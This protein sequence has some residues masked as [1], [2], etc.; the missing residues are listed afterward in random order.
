MRIY[1]SPSDQ[2]SNITASGHSEADH[3]LS[4]AKAAEKYLKLNGYEAKIG[5]NTTEKSYT[6]RVAES[7]NWS[8]NLHVC[9]HTNAGGGKGT[10]VMCYPGYKENT[11]VKNVYHCLDNLVPTTGKG[12]IEKTDLYEINKTKAVCVYC[13][14]EFH[15]SAE[16]ENWID[17]NVDGIGKAIAK[18]ICMG[19][20]RIFVDS[21]NDYQPTSGL[22]KVQIGAFTKYEN[23]K[24]LANKLKTLGYSSYIVKE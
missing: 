18:G 8:A 15:D 21:V 11:F 9:I 7:N 10:L 20:N 5:D 16:T 3:C 19:D 22:Y 12:I 24:A 1:L 23:A 2:H 4:I 13:E 17:A 14:C 6:S